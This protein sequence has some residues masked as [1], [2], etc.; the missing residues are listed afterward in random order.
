VTLRLPA[1]T[2]ARVDVETGSGGIDT[3]FEV[4]V[5]RMERRALHGTIGDGH[6]R[7]RVEA[8]SGMVRLLKN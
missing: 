4:H 2:G 6:G 7:I 5:A 1:A 8:G 3:D